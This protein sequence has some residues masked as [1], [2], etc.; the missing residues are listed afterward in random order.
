[1][2]NEHLANERTYL[3][4]M[5]TSLGIAAFGFVIERFAMFTKLSHAYLRKL[6][7]LEQEMPALY[8]QQKTADFGIYLIVFGICMG[9][10]AFSKYLRIKNEL[11]KGSCRYPTSVMEVMLI[12]AFL[13]TGVWLTAYSILSK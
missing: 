10:M 3:A 8:L 7:V 6:G 13:V 12:L 5:R 9:L 4:W 2:I 1:M 11:I